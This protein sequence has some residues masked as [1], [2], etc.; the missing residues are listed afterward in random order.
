MTPR[1]YAMSAAIA[2]TAGTALAQDD[3][4]FSTL[5]ADGSGGISLAELQA[6]GANV[7]EETFA[8]YDT[9]ASGELSAEEYAAWAGGGR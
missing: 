4:A 9:D 6:A 5:D 7:T 1:L 3:S 8:L 2:L